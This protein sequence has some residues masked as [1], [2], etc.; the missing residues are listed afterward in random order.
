MYMLGRGCEWRLLDFL[1]WASLCPL[2]LELIDRP[3]GLGAGDFPAGIASWHAGT[4]VTTLRVP[5][6]FGSLRLSNVHNGIR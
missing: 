4:S 6:L 3:P 5:A 1:G 2:K